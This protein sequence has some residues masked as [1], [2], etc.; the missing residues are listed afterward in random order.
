MTA[1]IVIGCILLLLL[2]IMLL[3]L[4]LF[5]QV[6][7]EDLSLHFGVLMFKFKLYP[8]EIKKIEKIANNVEQRAEKEQQS[9]NRNNKTLK[10]D[11]LSHKK[12]NNKSSQ[13]KNKS[14][15]HK[16]RPSKQVKEKIEEKTWGETFFLIV[17]II[18]AVVRPTKFMLRQIQITGFSLRAIIGGE[19]PD[20]TAIRFGY[21]NAAVY[22]GLA[23]LRNFFRVKCKKINIAVDFTAPET[24]VWAEGILKIR[25]FVVVFAAVRMFFN[26]LVNTFKR[27]KANEEPAN[28]VKRKAAA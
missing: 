5:F 8:K 21:W 9:G 13:S 24:Q 26:I 1:F 11:I 22:G 7:N 25:V 27:A 28:Q 23:T 16:K 18:Q 12:E 19:E 2:F 14:Q 10:S 15:S 3:P 20:E 4:K 17:D 6:E